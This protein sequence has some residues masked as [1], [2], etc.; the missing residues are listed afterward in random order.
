MFSTM[1]NSLTT[2]VLLSHVFVC[3]M[4]LIRDLDLA[5]GDVHDSNGI[6]IVG[7][8]PMYVPDMYAPPLDTI[9]AS[10]VR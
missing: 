3:A 10:R 2:Y 7:L 1:I 9:R 5:D 6:Y 4:S 8:V